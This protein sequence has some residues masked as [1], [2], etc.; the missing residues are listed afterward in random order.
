MECF[1]VKCNNF[2]NRLDPNFYRPEY[3]KIEARLANKNHSNLADIISFSKETWNQ[4]DFFEDKFPYIEISAID[5]LTGKINNIEY[6]SISNA[7][8]R[9][10]MIV[11][12]NDIILSTTRPHRGA[13]SMISKEL[14]GFIA[15]TGFAII[16]KLKNK[17]IDWNYLF[18]ILR[19]ELILKQLQRRS[20]GGNYPAI[21]L[22]ELAKI[23]IPVPEPAIQ[24]EIINIFDELLQKYNSK[25]L[26]TK[27]LLDSINDYVLSELGIELPELKDKTTY[28]V[29]SKEIDNRVDPYYYQPKFK[30]LYKKIKGYNKTLLLKSIV[31]ELDYGLM[32][33]QDYAL[34]EEYGVPMIRVTNIL[35]DGTIDMSDVK[36]IPFNTPKLNLKRVREHDILMVQCGS[37]TGKVAI[38]P[39]AYENYTF[40]SFSFVIRGKK[41]IVN[42]YFLWAILSNKLVQQQIKQSWN[43][44][45]VRP[46]TSKPNVGNLLIP[47]PSLSIQQKIA[48]EVKSRMD[49]AKQLQKE[50]QETLGQARKKA[51]QMILGEKISV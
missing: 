30:E 14:D 27:E 12:E 39:K 46:N 15:S 4:K 9:A 48:D 16:R 37:T 22:D 20:S 40:G 42:Q 3:I 38:V 34:S 18:H 2:E 19:T 23:L 45:T 32:P 47:I 25:I 10:K 13:I 21:T 1:K 35:Q 6:H 8:S 26:K 41:E 24:R 17:L 31:E 5:T 36:Y 43:I 49:E 51:E 11:R 29:N 28:V 33:T 7:P 44:V 50:A